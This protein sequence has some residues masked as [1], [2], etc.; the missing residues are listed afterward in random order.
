MKTPR[1]ATSK[2]PAALRTL[3]GVAKIGEGTVEQAMTAI[4]GR[5]A[6]HTTWCIMQDLM[7]L[8]LVDGHGQDPMMAPGY[9]LTYTA[10]DLGLVILAWN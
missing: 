9:P 2:I 3:A 6:V 1:I 8:G 10:T 4:G 7:A 5:K